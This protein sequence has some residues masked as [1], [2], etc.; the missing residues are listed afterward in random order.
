V[1]L[2]EKEGRSGFIIKITKFAIMPV[3]KNTAGSW[4]E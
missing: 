2:P 4:G 1:S 3:L